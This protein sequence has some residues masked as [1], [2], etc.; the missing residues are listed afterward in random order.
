[1]NRLDQSLV[2]LQSQR[3]HQRSRSRRGESEG[4]FLGRQNR[5]GARLSNQTPSSKLQYLKRPT[6]FCLK[7]GDW[8]FP[9]VWLLGFGI[10]DSPNVHPLVG[11]ADHRAVA[12]NVKCLRELGQ[13]RER[14]VHP[15][16]RG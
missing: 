13:I 9:G 15:V 5:A 12:R 6:R 11:S 3:G 10:L 4:P 1:S 14:S 8:V 16:A 2:I 7:F